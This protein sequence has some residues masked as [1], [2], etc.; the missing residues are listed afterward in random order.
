MQLKIRGTQAADPI[1]LQY[2]VGGKK[3]QLQWLNSIVFTVKIKIIGYI[4]KMI[5]E[6]FIFT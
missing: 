6:E 2:A 3:L 1:I 4:D 5:S